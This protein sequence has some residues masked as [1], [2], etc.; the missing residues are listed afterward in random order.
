MSQ[1]IAYADFGISK[2]IDANGVITTLLVHRREANDSMK[3]LDWYAR[4][5]IIES[6]A[7]NGSTYMTI[8]IDKATNTWSKGADIH[9]V[10]MKDGKQYLRTDR[11][12]IAADNLDN[13]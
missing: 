10:T 6:I 2:V 12:Q 3:Q 11:N 5:A 8:H 13:L 9:V 1:Q 4:Q 7:K